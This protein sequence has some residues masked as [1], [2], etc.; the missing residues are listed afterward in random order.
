M[1][2]GCNSVRIFDTAILIAEL[3]AAL[4]GL[5]Y[6]THVLRAS[7]IYLEEDLLIVIAWLLKSQS[8]DAR[9]CAVLQDCK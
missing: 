3:H 6:A 5:T 4:K 1:K 2:L 7:H 9:P 8:F